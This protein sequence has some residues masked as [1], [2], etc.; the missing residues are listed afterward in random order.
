M[1]VKKPSRGALAALVA[2]GA[3]LGLAAPASA[4]TVIQFD[5]ATG[6]L[7]V[8]FDGPSGVELGSAA[9]KVTLN[10]GEQQVDAADVKT[11]EVLEDPAGTGAN[12][13]DLSAVDASAYT[14]LTSTLIQAAGGD[15][16]LTGSQLDDRIV[17]GRNADT[18]NGRDG[19]DTLVWNN[20]DGNDEMNGGD[21]IDTIESNGAD[22][23][24][25]Y[26]VETAGK[27]F[28]FKR[29]TPN[30][31]QLDVGGAER[32]VNNLRGGDDRFSTLDPTQA[33]AGIDVTL[34]GEAG[35]DA[36]TGTND[37]DVLNGGADNDTLVGF[38][39]NDTMNGGDG[40]DTMTWNNGDGTDRM[41]GGAG[42]DVAQQNGANAGNDN[43]IVSANGQRVTATRDNLGPFF[44]DIST[45]ETLQVNGQGGDDS[46]DVNNGLAPLIAVQ[47]NLGDGNDSI[48]ARND[49]AQTIDG[50]AGT[51][52]A[53]VDATDV[54]SNVET[55]DAPVVTP[56]PLPE[57]D[58]KAPKAAIKSQRLKVDGGRA[59]V[60]FTVPSD[61]EQ[62]DA[63]IRILRG[64]KIVG[65]LKI[66]DLDGG[67]TRTVR[68]Q[69]KRKTR[70][71]LANAQG[72][73]LRAT[74]KIQLTDD[75][76]NKATATKRLNLKG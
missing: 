26:T 74:L 2:A 7:T 67:D 46:V 44:L 51:D 66:S 64:G 16:E 62:V 45:T 23:A 71:A 49:S 29:V 53:V 22:A 68:V 56:P 38:R 31:F 63:R 18:M 8:T 3:T 11:I 76:G 24:E 6:K 39:G 60:R 12:T 48:E 58:E 17:G 70:I 9:G 21:G 57:V 47:V 61:E 73:K 50:G 41:D 54:L 25:T 32:Y 65:S 4:D 30:P 35:N 19:D 28:L 20:G 14:Q 69:L 33:V 34:N 36:L 10:G 37:A 27:R 55:V 13:V 15:D 72:Q 43:F 59:K 5:A 1:Q 42:S 75:A 52:S 40:N